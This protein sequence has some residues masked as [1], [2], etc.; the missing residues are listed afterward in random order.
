MSRKEAKGQATI[1]SLMFG[2]SCSENTTYYKSKEDYN[3]LTP[4]QKIVINEIINNT[5]WS[6]FIEDVANTYHEGKAMFYTLAQAVC[7][8]SPAWR[9]ELS[10][11]VIDALFQTPKPWVSQNRAGFLLFCSETLITHYLRT[12]LQ[13]GF[14]CLVAAQL[15]QLVLVSQKFDKKLSHEKGIGK[16]FDAIFRE[17]IEDPGHTA[18][19]TKV[20]NGFVEE[21]KEEEGDVDSSEMIRSFHAHIIET[22]T[23][24]LGKKEKKCS[25]RKYALPCGDDES[26]DQGPKCKKTKMDPDT[27]D[28]ME[29]VPSSSDD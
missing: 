8:L 12:K 22:L 29:L 6:V 5:N 21:A 27:T 26:V 11:A 9:S 10:V 1:L 23:A 3:E 14:D 28:K 7:S 15:A 19:S 18:F 25:L 4:N 16:V 20:W 2:P 24:E 13:R 17:S